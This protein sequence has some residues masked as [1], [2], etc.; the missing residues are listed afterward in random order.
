M[1]AS[2]GVDPQS[3]REARAR[4]GLTQHGLARVIGVAGGERVSRWE[5]GSSAPRPSQLVR[6]ADALGVGVG[7]LLVE[8]PQDLRRLRLCAGLSAREVADRAYL[9]LPTYV[10]WEAGHLAKIPSRNTLEPLARALCCTLAELEQAFVL[11]RAPSG[12]C[13]GQEPER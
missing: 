13:A 7:D 6:L 4:A 9:S 2:P 1:P 8:A 12:R 3:L 5:L 11:A 10:R